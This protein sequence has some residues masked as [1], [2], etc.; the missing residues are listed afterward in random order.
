MKKLVLL[1]LAFVT[2]SLTAIAQSPEGFKYQAVVRNASNVILANQ[3]VGLR[4]IIQQG[5]IG[6]TSVYS[7]TFAVTTNANGLVNVEIGNGS[8]L[9]GTFASID[10][11]NGPY[12]I[13]TA[14]DAAGGTAYSVMGTSQLM[15]VPYALY[16]KTSGS[17]QNLNQ[18]LVNGNNANGNNLV[19]TGTIGVGTATPNS[20]AAIDITSTTG[21][22]LLPRMTTAQRNNLTAAEG[23]MI[24]NTT[25]TQYQGYGYGTVAGT[26]A[27]DQAQL[28]FDNAS[29]ESDMSQS[30]TAGV[31]GTLSSARVL[32]NAMGPATDATIY[33]RSGVGNAGA[34]LYQTT[35]SVTYQDGGTWYIINPTGVSV[36][37]GNNYTINMTSNG[38]GFMN[39][40]NW[41]LATNNPYAAGNAFLGSNANTTSNFNDFFGYDFAFE[42]SVSSLT[43]G[44]LGWINLNAS[45][46]GATGA[47][48]PQGPAGNNGVDGAPGAAGPQG[49]AGPAGEDGA[50]GPQGPVGDIGATGPVGDIGATGPQGPAGADGVGSPQNLEQVLVVGNNANGLNVV[51]TGTIGVG[52]ATPSTESSIEIATALPIIFPRMNQSQIN[53]L[54]PT[55]GMVQY[56]TDAKKLQVYGM[57]TDNAEVL[58][59][60]YI[61]NESA[62]GFLLDQSFSSPI[63]GQVIAVE[64]MFKDGMGYESNID[65][66]GQGMYTVPSYS[67][68]TW[69]TFILTNPIP[70]SAGGMDYFT[71]FGP[72]VDM[73]SF[74]TNS[75]YPNGD[76]MCCLM[77]PDNDVLFRVH[78]QPVP[79]SFGWQN[80]N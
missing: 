65:F 23:M 26:P 46:A 62:G 43:A 69:H 77:T 45:S 2:V 80:L 34:I 30:F 24:Y 68:F 29:M 41:L 67:Q 31:S 51:N 20:S 17:T 19:N 37:A 3:A 47:T 21:S 28:N 4:M 14:V 71:F 7:E 49:P 32:L 55:E 5:S 50:P 66:M 12:F 11:A 10:W 38:G 75:N 8:V 58:N 52:T 36:I 59:E 33:I 42:T 39:E 1:L 76:L 70:V 56:N 9:S 73:R 54:T 35:V 15:S 64:L 40:I 61:G 78:I 18:V 27:V 22:L 48:G 13:E 57:L 53:A 74:A 60:I 72:G 16:A 79:G 44:S 6:G 25:E 63:D